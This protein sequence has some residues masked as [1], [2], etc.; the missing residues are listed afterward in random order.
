MF[1]IIFKN[2]QILNYFW[3]LFLKI[4]KKLFFDFLKII[5]YFCIFLIF[6]KLFFILKIFSPFLWSNLKIIWIH[7][8]GHKKTQKMRG[9]KIIFQ[10]FFILKIIFWKLFFRIKIF[11]PFLTRNLKIIWNH[12]KGH[13]NG[14]QNQ[15]QNQK[16]LRIR[17]RIRILSSDYRLQSQ[18]IRY[19]IRIDSDQ[20]YHLYN[21]GWI[22]L[23]FNKGWI[24]I[25]EEIIS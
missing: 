25:R 17:I 24:F 8:K 18:S 2:V 15:N 5:F 11:S 13:K 19:Q 20:N 10:K 16:S 22:F 3:K 21:G 12:K 6:W 9:Q 1:F 7:K 4:F 14:Y 23:A